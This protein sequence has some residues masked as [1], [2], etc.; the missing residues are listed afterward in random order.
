MKILNKITKIF[1]SVLKIFFITFFIILILDLIL[2]EK[3]LKI[4]DPYLKET[5]FYDKRTRISHPIFHHTFRKNV[6][7]KSVGF[8]KNLRLCS[9]QYGFKSNCIYIKK[10]FYEFGL[11][12]D[13]FTEGIG[14]SYENTFSGL[15]E[16]KLNSSI[17]NLGVSSYSSKIHLAKL[18]H[19]LN[20][21]I[22]FKHIIIF[23]DIS[24]Y[25]DD[26]YY[27]LDDKSMSIQ[28][29]NR[30]K[31]KIQLRKY[32]PFTNYYFYVIKKIKSSSQ[33][34]KDTLNNFHTNG[35]IN[36]WFSN[37][38]VIKKTNWLYKELDDYKINNK[39]FLD[40]HLEKKNY[41]NKIYEL[42]KKENIKFSLAIYPWPHNLVTNKN[43][44]FYKN[45]WKNF[46]KS[47][48]EFFFD[49]FEEFEKKIK[50]DSLINVYKKYYFWGD[51]HFNEEGNKLIAEKLI[52][53]LLEK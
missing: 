14:L 3:V 41:L 46:C 9:N 2:G 23:L 44:I 48:C 10:K 39:N 35:K 26:A 42:L 34:K 37:E 5:E 31:F 16:R 1:K 8:G 38:S 19:Y 15:L 22:K 4:I 20:E 7:F 47:K 51:I 25:Y 30:E 13:S 12:G 6:N 28:F 18:N 49:Y 36:N 24:D 32:F 21:G 52:K 40:I 11:L 50:N 45:E 43:S 27:N 29:S 53:D 17:A 33:S